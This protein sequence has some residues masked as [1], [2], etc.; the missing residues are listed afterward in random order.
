PM[1]VQA[2]ASLRSK[3][4]TSRPASPRTPLRCIFTTSRSLNST[5]RT[6]SPSPQ[7]MIGRTITSSQTH[8]T[9]SGHRTKATSSVKH[10]TKVKQKHNITTAR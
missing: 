3:S 6:H 1:C 5:H 2:G 7:R 4:A 10:T 9:H 8:V